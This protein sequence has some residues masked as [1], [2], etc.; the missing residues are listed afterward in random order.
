MQPQAVIIWTERFESSFQTV[1]S[2]QP[3]E[4]PKFLPFRIPPEGLH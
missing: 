1:S 2:S 3:L 4:Y